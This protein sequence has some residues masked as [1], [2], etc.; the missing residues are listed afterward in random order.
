MGVAGG[1]VKNSTAV[2]QWP[3]FWGNPGETTGWHADQ[4]WCPQ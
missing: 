4:F 2:I 1:K 3:F